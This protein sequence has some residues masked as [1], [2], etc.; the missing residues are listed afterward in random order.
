MEPIIILVFV[1]VTGVLI[2]GACIVTLMADTDS[3]LKADVEV[4]T[5]A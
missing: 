4:V 3:A 2:G 1:F 5:R